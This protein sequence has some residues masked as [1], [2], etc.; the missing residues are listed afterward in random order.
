MPFPFNVPI[1]DIER[2]A[3]YEAFMRKLDEF[4]QS[5]G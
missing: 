4:H 1:R 3:E 5:K 2:T